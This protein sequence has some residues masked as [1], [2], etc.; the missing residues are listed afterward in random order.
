MNL[1][2]GFIALLLDFTREEDL[3]LVDLLKSRSREKH[4][5]LQTNTPLIVA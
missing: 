3:E 2:L 5:L 1:A 4:F